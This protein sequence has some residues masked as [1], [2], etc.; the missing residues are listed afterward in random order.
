MILKA[1]GSGVAAAGVAVA[2]AA[3]AIA[4]PAD[5][6]F[7]ATIRAQNVPIY[8]EQYVIQLGHNVCEAA[9]QYPSM[10]VVDLSFQEVTSESEA[11]PYDYANGRVI[12]TSALA[13]YCPDA[14]SRT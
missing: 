6:A 12:T 11:R 14:G 4:T 10:Q 5:D 9:R 3:T 8:G 1:L 2:A 7:L 13:N